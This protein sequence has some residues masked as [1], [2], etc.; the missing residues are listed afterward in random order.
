MKAPYIIRLENGRVLK[1]DWLGPGAALLAGGITASAGSPAVPPA[2][3]HRLS[4]PPSKTGGT[5]RKY[6]RT[7]ETKRTTICWTAFWCVQWCTALT[8]P[9]SETNLN[10]KRR[11]RH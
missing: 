2:R 1:D 9:A 4:C 5:A 6:C 11:L 7:N 10:L 3:S 8:S